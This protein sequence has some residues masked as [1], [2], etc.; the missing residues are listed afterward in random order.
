MQGEYSFKETNRFKVIKK[1]IKGLM[2]TRVI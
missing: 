1:A 2:F